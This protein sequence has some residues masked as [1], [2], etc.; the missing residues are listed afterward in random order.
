MTALEN[1]YRVSE[2]LIERFVKYSF[3]VIDRE[4]SIFDVDSTL[5]LLLSIT[6]FFVNVKMQPR[7]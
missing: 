1:C 4:R 2:G 7:M 6:E 5:Q 3:K